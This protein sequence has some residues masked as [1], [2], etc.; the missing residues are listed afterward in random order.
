MKCR[1]RWSKLTSLTVVPLA[2]IT[3]LSVFRAPASALVPPEEEDGDAR[4]AAIFGGFQSPD[5]EVQPSLEVQPRGTRKALGN[6][7]LQRFFAYQ[8]A[9]WEVR[10]DRR[11]DRPNLIQGA[12]IPLLPGHGN[13]L[14]AS[15]LKLA[16]EGGPSMADVEARLRA[17]MDELPELL[18]VSGFDLRLDERSSVNAGEEKQI[19]FV[20]LQQF[21]RGVPVE[22][23]KVYFRINNGNIVQ[24]GTER[25]AEVR[26]SASPKIG[27]AAALA[28]A[29]RILG[30]RLDE[31]QEIRNPGT[32]KLVPALT[33]GE[34]PAEAFEGAPG[35]GY[36][37]YLVW[38]VELQRTG[39]ASVYQARVD[40]RNGRVLSLVDLTSYVNA[41]VTGGIYPTTNTDPE[42]VV[43]LPFT[44]VT[45]GSTKVTDAA[46][47][48]NYSGGKATVTLNG[49]Y[50]RMADSC[51]PVSKS[52]GSTGNIAFGTRG[53]TP[54]TVPRAG[55]A[56][57]T[58]ATRTGYYHLTN[59][60]R[61]AA[62][63]L[64]GN[65]WLNGTLTA[66]MNIN[67]TCNAYWNGSTVNFYRSG[68][69]CSNTGEIAAVF[70]HEWGHGLDAHAGGAAPDK[71]TG[72]AVGDTFA[73]L[74]TKDACI[75]QNFKP[76]VACRNCNASCT[77]ARDLAA[78]ASGGSHTIARPS[79]VAD[80]NGLNCRR[81]SCPYM[82]FGLAPYQGPM[83]YEGH[84]E[85]YI[86]STANW[87]LAQ[88]LIARWG[89]AAGWARMDSLWYRSLVPSKSAYQVVSGGKCNPAAKVNGCGASNWYT[90]YLAADDDDGNL[91]NGTPNGCRIWDAFT[92]H[93]IAC[94]ARPAC[95]S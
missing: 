64:P 51:G 75:G 52:D 54:C 11:N 6:P 90:V 59:I 13:A 30:S 21:H 48:Y 89:T 95:T 56:G 40:A 3:G 5:L 93:G 42:K 16:H 46:G 20:E 49:K 72:E 36:R 77:G 39:D 9:D 27:R 24:L 94:G 23:A 80:A 33:A 62:R 44:Y 14:A 43:G 87:D 86:A 65:S 29:L 22:G 47:N 78:F 19:W 66:N 28:A 71:G 25:V 10:W 91:A 2:L 45:N 8:S 50:I 61:K 12:G 7:A 81:F 41:Q 69:G 63:F 38:E 88:Q 73:F 60:N 4:L 55:G 31:I 58:K 82:I 26:V 70:L 57:N 67:A 1:S 68:N 34:R 17:F 53:G 32:L 76:G 15:A 92:A 85:S 83:G 18:G 35:R 84:C 37:H 79:T 74:E